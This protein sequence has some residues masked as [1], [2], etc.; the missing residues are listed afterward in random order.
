L[1]LHEAVSSITGPSGFP[2]PKERFPGVVIPHVNLERAD[3]AI[4][5]R[6]VFEF[7]PNGRFGAT[8]ADIGG[9]VIIT[10]SG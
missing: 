1:N 6:V 4:K 3:L 5:E 8:Y 2:G 10:A 7:E 9:N